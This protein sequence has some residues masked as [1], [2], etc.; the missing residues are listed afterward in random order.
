MRNNDQAH[1][2]LRISAMIFV[3]A[4]VF[5]T[6]STKS[7]WSTETT[8]EPV[9]DEHLENAQKVAEAAREEAERAMAEAE[10][11]M[12]EAEAVINK[13]Q[14]AK[15]K[16]Q[17]EK[18]HAMEKMVGAGYFP[19]DI[20]LT[21]A[22]GKVSAVFSH[23]KHTSREKLKCIECHPR[24]FIMKV[25]D[26]IIKEGNLTME[27]MKKGKYCGNCHNGQKAFSVNDIK[28]CRRCHPKQK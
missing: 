22:D 13:A 3:V 19:D 28:S 9:I 23:K 18:A 12:A 25:D 20:T 5:V 26:K 4:L 11:A 6:G 14:D 2:I 10:R 7:G 27:E 15:R 16:A 17:E 24:I 8:T 1:K 21:D